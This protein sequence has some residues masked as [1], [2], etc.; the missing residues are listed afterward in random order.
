MARARLV[1]LLIAV[2]VSGALAVAVGTAL[3]RTS[4]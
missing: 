4:S 1:A 3:L 2:V